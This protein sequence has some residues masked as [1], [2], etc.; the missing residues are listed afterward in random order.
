MMLAMYIKINIFKK[1]IFQG[2]KLL[3]I[4]GL[5]EALVFCGLGWLLSGFT[6]NILP[7]AHVDIM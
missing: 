1:I 2:W 6:V 7:W 3:Y 5:V 4:I